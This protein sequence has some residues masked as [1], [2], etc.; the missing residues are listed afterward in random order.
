MFKFTIRFEFV[1]CM[2]CSESRAVSPR[3]R[4]AVPAPLWKDLPVKLPWPLCRQHFLRAVWLSAL[5]SCVP[6]APTPTPHHLDRCSF[7][8]SLLLSNGLAVL[9]PCSSVYILESDHQFVTS[10]MG[11][12]LWSPWLCRPFE[13]NL[14]RNNIESSDP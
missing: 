1:L 4:P 13:G 7:A 2:V 3:A 8:V 5:S 11:P 12:S 10:L 9:A 6:S 14:H